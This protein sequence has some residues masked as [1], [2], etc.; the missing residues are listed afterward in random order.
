[1]VLLDMVVFSI[2][3][4]VM[5]LDVT[6]LVFTVLFVMFE[7]D[8]VLAVMLLDSIRELSMSLWLMLDELIVELST[9]VLVIV[10]FAICDWS[11]VEL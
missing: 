1:M 9:V 10:E 7:S 8:I 3:E 6:E 11:I 5:L 4:F 2:S